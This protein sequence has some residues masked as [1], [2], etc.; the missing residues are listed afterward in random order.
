MQLRVTP[1][2]VLL[3]RAEQLDPDQWWFWTEE[4]QAGERRADED[5]LLGRVSRPYT[6]AGFLA[7]LDAVIDEEPPLPHANL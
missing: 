1:D 7:L 3:C 2:G 4:W 6:G 5:K